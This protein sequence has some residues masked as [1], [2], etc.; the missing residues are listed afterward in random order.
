MK[1]KTNR[2]REREKERKKERK[3]ERERE[4]RGGLPLPNHDVTE[5]MFLA[6][7]SPEYW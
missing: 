3:K 2:E 7:R 6:K 1:R 5:V 4:R